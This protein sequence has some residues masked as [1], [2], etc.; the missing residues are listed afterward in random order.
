MKLWTTTLAYGASG[1]GEPG[2]G[3]GLD[4][5]SAMRRT[6]WKRTLCGGC[7]RAWR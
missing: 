4:D 6:G 2:G 5:L 7:G 3:A 1:E